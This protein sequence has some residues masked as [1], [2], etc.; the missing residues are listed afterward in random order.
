M[1]FRVTLK[2]LLR[3]LGFS[4][5]V[6][7]CLLLLWLLLVLLIPE[8][9]SAIAWANMVLLLMMAS[10]TWGERWRVILTNRRARLMPGLGRHAIPTMATLLALQILVLVGL[11]SLT[12]NDWTLAFGTLLP[13]AT[14]AA[15]AGLGMGLAGSRL[16]FLLALAF[17]AWILLTYYRP[18]WLAAASMPPWLLLLA[19]VS[20]LA[21]VNALRRRLLA[22]TPGADLRSSVA[23]ARLG[24]G[25]TAKELLVLGVGVLLPGLALLSGRLNEGQTRQLALMAWTAPLCVILP[26]LWRHRLRKAQWRRLSLL[27][28]WSNER[29]GQRLSHALIQSAVLVV[30]GQWLIVLASLHAGLAETARMSLALLMSPALAWLTV[31][32]L[33][34]LAL[35]DDDQLA[36]IL[37]LGVFIGLGFLVLSSGSVLFFGIGHY[38]LAGL[39]GIGLFA[40]IGAQSLR[41]GRGH[42]WRQAEF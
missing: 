33:L 34:R 13:L 8:R 21:W 3:S 10:D 29:L 38:P 32:T 6:W 35:V 37:Y 11:P 42:A 39:A 25:L 18:E 26:L 9:L 28:N 41:A 17:P 22:G 12:L 1:T 5:L 20:S 15:L 36:G 40:L 27:P 16:R 31:E 23:A 7:Q 2:T 30:L 19:L 4:G 14:I 24:P